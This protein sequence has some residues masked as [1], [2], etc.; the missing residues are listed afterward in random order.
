MKPSV[1][2]PLFWDDELSENLRSVEAG[3]DRRDFNLVCD[4]FCERSTVRNSTTVHFRLWT[5]C[6]GDFTVAVVHVEQ[7]VRV[8]V[9][10]D[11]SV[12][13]CLLGVQ[14]LKHVNTWIRT[15]VLPRPTVSAVLLTF[16]SKLQS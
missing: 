7:S 13:S 14:D 8:H 12:V 11:G 3:E 5:F 1:L 10:D 16:I 6:G 2:L 4:G 15:A 9:V